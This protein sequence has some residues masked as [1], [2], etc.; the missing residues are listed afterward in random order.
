MNFIK[1]FKVK[2]PCNE[3]SAELRD[4]LNLSLL[5]M[6]KYYK[7][8]RIRSHANG[9][10]TLEGSLSL[11]MSLTGA[12]SPVSPY[13]A[14]TDRFDWRWLSLD[15]DKLSAS[16][17]HGD[18]TNFVPEIFFVVKDCDLDQLKKMVDEGM[19]TTLA[20]HYFFIHL[21]TF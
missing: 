2:L 4:S 15:V 5:H 21:F 16:F 9:G 17:G 14:P 7:K 12:A 8:A 1:E 18:K 13:I 10:N 19:F 6:H 3:T 20:V 11:S